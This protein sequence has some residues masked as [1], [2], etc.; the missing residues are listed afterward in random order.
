MDLIANV[1][2]QQCLWWQLLGTGFTQTA[3][4]ATAATIACRWQFKSQQIL[5]AGGVTRLSRVYLMPD[6]QLAVG[7]LV[8]GPGTAFPGNTADPQAA[9]TPALQIIKVETINTID[10]DDTFY[11][12]WAV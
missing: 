12:A 11:Q 7:D 3:T 1:R 6:R 8:W 4:Y 2:I 9:D 10:G 5:D